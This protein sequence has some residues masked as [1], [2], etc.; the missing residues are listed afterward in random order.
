MD[1]KH[2]SMLKKL[3]RVLALT[4]ACAI[5]LT[6]CGNSTTESPDTTN[7]SEESVESIDPSDE[8]VE[9]IDSILSSIGV[10][11]DLSFEANRSAAATIEYDGTETSVEV[12]DD[13]GLTWQL[14]IPENALPEKH[15]I[16]LTPLT[17][18][19]GENK[20]D[21]LSGILMEPDGLEFEDPATLTVTGP[22]ADKLMF[23]A[24]TQDGKNYTY[25]PSK[26]LE[27]GSKLSVYHFSSEV[28][29]NIFSDPK[30]YEELLDV[31]KDL[32]KQ[33]KKSLSK[34]IKVPDVKEISLECYK[35]IPNSAY[36]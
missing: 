34:S 14:T 16:I 8:S 11:E 26:I 25:Q 23:L 31:F 35:G 10:I 7:P 27:N 4:V 6:A 1:K 3:E 18:I 36:Q 13:K 29:S 28:A 2:E 5:L 9:S 33:V 17:N 21:G 32:E 20:K 24:G 19:Q 22:D 12:I 30:V 15:T